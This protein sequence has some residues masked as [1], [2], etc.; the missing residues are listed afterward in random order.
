MLESD[1][2]KSAVIDRA[3]SSGRTEVVK[4]VGVP[5]IDA[6]GTDPFVNLQQSKCTGFQTAILAVHV[7]LFPFL[8]RYLGP[9]DAE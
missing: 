1:V 5:H 2:V 6:Y 4:K 8:C 9:G 3:H 7:F